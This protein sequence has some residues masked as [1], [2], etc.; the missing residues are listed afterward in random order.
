M[1]KRGGDFVTL[2]ALI[3]DLGV[4]VARFFLL[5]RSHETTLDLDL[6]LAREQS[7][8]NPVYYVQYAHARIASILRRADSEGLAQTQA[9]DL[10]ESAEVLDP[11]ARALVALL[12]ELPGEVGLAAARRA[13]HRLTTY[14]LEVAQGFSAFYRDVRVIGAAEEGGDEGFR[15]ALCAQTARVLGRSLDLLGVAAPERM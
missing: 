11:S 14:A 9:E 5:Q 7:Q 12:L 10:A 13:P 6:A 3:D 1:S 8:E 4:D 15:L 2:D